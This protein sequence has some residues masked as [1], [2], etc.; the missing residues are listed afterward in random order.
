MT[1]FS[2]VL[3]H[4][5]YI[6]YLVKFQESQIENIKILFDLIKE[7]NA[8]IPRLAARLILSIQTISIYA[9]KIVCSALKTYG[10]V[11]SEFEI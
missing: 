9:K 3:Q 8:F 10:I 11:I 2:E 7:I 5:S 4:I 6:C 1:V